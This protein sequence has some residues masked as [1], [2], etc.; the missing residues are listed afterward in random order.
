MEPDRLITMTQALERSG[1]SARTFRKRLNEQAVPIF[2]CGVDR[3]RRLVR[4]ADID[5][6]FTPA[7]RLAPLNDA[8]RQEAAGGEG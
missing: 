3:R 1:L 6:V 4:W 5:A 2:A 7:R 8:A